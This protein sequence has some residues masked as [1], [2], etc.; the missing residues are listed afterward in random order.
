MRELFLLDVI[1]LSF[2]CFNL[3][4]TVLML[5]ISKLGLHLF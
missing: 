2:E 1:K 4:G 5:V 3:E